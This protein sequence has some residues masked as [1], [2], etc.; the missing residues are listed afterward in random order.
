MAA[1]LQHYRNR[2]QTYIKHQFLTKYLQVAAYKTLQGRSK[3][4]NFV[5]AFAGPWKISDETEYSDA[6]FDQ[7]INTL[8][9]V[10]VDLGRRGI[11]GLKIRFCLC[12][13]T[14]EAFQKLR[15]YAEGQSKF[16]IHVFP[17]EFENN[18]DAIKNKIPGGFTFTFIDPKGWKIRNREVFD[19]LKA[20][21]GDFL[22][23][24]MADHINR[25]AEYSKVVESFGLFLAD[26]D[27][28]E[29]FARLPSNWTNEKC[30]LYLLKKNLRSKGVANYTPDF[31]I[32][33]P[34]KERVKM[35]LILGTNSFHGLEVFR[36]VQSKVEILQAN[37][38]EQLRQE[39]SEE[40]FL[41]GP[42]Q[43]STN[44]L[45]NK[46]VG[47]KLAVASAVEQIQS[48]ILERAVI[49][50]AE[51]AALVL[52]ELPIRLTQLKDLL[53]SMRQ[54]EKL[55]FELPARKQKP[56]GDTLIRGV[57]V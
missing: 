10:R 14:P 40:T 31:S 35:R 18:L 8:E 23:N 34:R 21:N 1:D 4:F 51:L 44:V 36:D 29:E 2:E 53:M 55:A 43:L 6:S 24:F 52:E 7:A 32:M 19:F 47:G 20:V 12:E 39:E 37:I 22:V 38:R 28:E 54:E 16:D 56:Q 57:S 33:V 27:W 48:I 42:D 3:I 17:G 45:Q 9:A 11:A 30:I 15:A 26:P 50:F 13:K 25:H 41:F 49:K 46:G 5:D